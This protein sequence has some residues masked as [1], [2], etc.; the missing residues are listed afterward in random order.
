MAQSELSGGAAQ[1][2]LESF[3]VVE[4]GNYMHLLPESWIEKIYSSIIL[5]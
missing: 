3:V 5:L 4:P 1:S 2:S